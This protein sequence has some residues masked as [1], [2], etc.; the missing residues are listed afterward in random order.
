MQSS[1]RKHGLLIL[2]LFHGMISKAASPGTCGRI[3]RT[4]GKRG[5]EGSRRRNPRG[6]A[7]LQQQTAERGAPVWSGDRHDRFRRSGSENEPR[8]R[9]Q[10]RKLANATPVFKAER[11]RDLPAKKMYEPRTTTGAAGQEQEKENSGS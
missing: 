2:S 8:E 10:E 5:N 4:A 7:I 6:F 9:K 1:L 3:I 11:P